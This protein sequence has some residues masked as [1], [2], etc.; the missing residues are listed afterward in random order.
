MPLSVLAGR[1]D[2]MRL[3]ERDV[4]CFTTFGGEALSLAAARACLRELVDRDVPDALEARGRRLRDGFNRLAA[5]HGVAGLTRCVGPAC[6][7]MV[8]L[9]APSG[10]DPLE[11]KSLLQQELIRRG[12]LWSGTHTLSY[13]HSDADIDRILDAYAEVL[14]L[15]GEASASGTVRARLCGA[16]I[17]PSFRRLSGFNVRPRMAGRSEFS[18]EGRVAIVTGAAG[19]LGRQ[20]AAALAQAGATVVL[21]DLELGAAERAAAGIE[22]VPRARLVAHGVDVT[23]VTGLARLRDQVIAQCG[24]VDILVNNAALNDKVEGAARTDAGW[25]HYSLDELRRMMDVNVAGVLLPCQLLGAEMAKRRSGRII[26][27]AS[28]Y[29]LVAPDP[30]LYDRP[31][32]SRLFTKAPAYPASKGAV[33][34]LTRYLATHLGASGV[35]V[36]ALVPGGVENGQDRY[37]IERYASRTPLRR[38]ARPDDFRGAL[39]FLAS[40]ASRYMTGAVMVVD[41][42]FTAW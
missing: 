34:A 30:A 36:N 1:A 39:V 4:F 31:D 18:L 25:E 28:T 12:I 8:T 11:L 15:L 23:D 6:R 26:N 13:S 22:G 3:L 32:G 20:H 33:V 9:T 35:T 37:F 38:M 7:T 17:E 2:V 27:I 40:D 10:G 41:G 14:P 16:P 29:A 21:V 19:L 5:E 24:R 42:G